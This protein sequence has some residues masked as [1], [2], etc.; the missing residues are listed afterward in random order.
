MAPDRRNAIAAQ[1]VVTGID[2]VYVAPDQVHLDVFF[3]N[4]PLALTSSL[5]SLAVSQLRIHE[6]L[7]GEVA[8][9]AMGFGV[10]DGRNVLQLTTAAPGG[11]RPYRLFIDD[12][13]ID[14]FFNDVRFD[15]K[16]NCP[17]E[18]DCEPPPHECPA[19][20]VPGIE[21]LHASPFH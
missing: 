9:V 19:R 16:A 13:R 2:F 15:F 12:A 8:I 14:A 20:S 18:I 21:R 10:A 4:D 3:L 5:A 7:L 11:F 1:N 6:D 17:S